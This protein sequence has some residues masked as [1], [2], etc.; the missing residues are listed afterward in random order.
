MRIVP[1]RVTQKSKNNF[2]LK[3]ELKL[4]ACNVK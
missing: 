2:T 4:D 1:C 3:I